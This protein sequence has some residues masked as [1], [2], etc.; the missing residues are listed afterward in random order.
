MNE[1]PGPQLT[2]EEITRSLQQSAGDQIEIARRL[3]G[4]ES[5]RPIAVVNGKIIQ[6]QDEI[7]GWQPKPWG[8]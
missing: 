3:T 7:R 4:I 2:D 5:P 1:K 6:Q 8:V